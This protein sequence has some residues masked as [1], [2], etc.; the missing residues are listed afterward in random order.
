M[1]F[2]FEHCCDVYAVHHSSS[3]CDV[4]CC[5]FGLLYKEQWFHILH[6]RKRQVFNDN[7]NNLTSCQHNIL[8]VSA[9]CCTGVSTAYCADNSLLLLS[10]KTLCTSDL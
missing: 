5:D 6:Q 4:M 2:L 1:E 7:W 9:G 10:I 8:I 3:D